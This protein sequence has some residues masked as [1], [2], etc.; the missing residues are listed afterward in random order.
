MPRVSRIREHEDGS[1][2]ARCRVCTIYKP[3]SAFHPCAIKRSAYV[4]K[5]CCN[6][7]MSIVQKTR[8]NNPYMRLATSIRTRERK[9][10]RISTITAQDVEA[11]FLKYQN[12]CVLTQRRIDGGAKM[13]L[14]PIDAQ[15]PLSKENCALVSLAGSAL[16][17]L[18]QENWIWPEPAMQRIRAAQANSVSQ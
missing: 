2:E 18:T 6:K 14:V 15:Q 5:L 3:V 16:H 12:A 17:E 11:A 13:S 7:K 1:K 4:C 9:N 10:G 8:M